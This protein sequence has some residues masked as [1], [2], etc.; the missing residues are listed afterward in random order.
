MN[1]LE[2]RLAR[3]EQQQE[4]RAPKFVW[5]NADETPEQVLARTRSGGAPIV[6]VSWQR[7]THA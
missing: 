6:L 2:A 5:M 1:R 7:R 3:V 4:V